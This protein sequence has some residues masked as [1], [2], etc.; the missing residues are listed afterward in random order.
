MYLHFCG[1]YTCSQKCHFQHRKHC[2]DCDEIPHVCFSR[3]GMTTESD[4]AGV[5]KG[6]RRH[7]E[8]VGLTLVCRRDKAS[9]YCFDGEKLWLPHCQ[10][11]ERIGADTVVIPLWLAQEKQ[12]IWREY[13]G[14]R[15]NETCSK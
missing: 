10:I 3:E 7:V 14:N 4:D 15:S 13:H 2:V 6:G 8:V 12:L 11:F 1:H 5:K 9:M